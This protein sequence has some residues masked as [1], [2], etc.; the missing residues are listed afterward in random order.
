MKHAVD[1]AWKENMAFATEIDGHVLQLDASEEFGGNDTGMR[2]KKLMLASLAGCTAMD[3]V[4]LLKKMRIN[5]DTFHVI[6]EGD[7]TEEHPKKYHSMNIIYQLT[8]ADIPRDKVE[9]AVSLSKDKYCGVSAAYK[10]S[11]ELSFEIRIN[12]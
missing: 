11:I 12:E 4:S 7:L 9:K 10:D 8:G 3:V 1:L 2:P 6:V 5:F